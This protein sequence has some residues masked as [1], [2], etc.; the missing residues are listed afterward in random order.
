MLDRAASILTENLRSSTLYHGP[1]EFEQGSLDMLKV[2]ASQCGVTVAPSFHPHAF[3]DI[4]VNGFGVE[5]KYTKNDTWLAVA[6]SIFEGMRDPSVRCVYVILGKTGG[7]AEVRWRRYEECITHV[8]VSNAP[9]FVVEMDG[10]RTPLFELLSVGYDEFSTF[11]AEEK[12]RHVRDYSRGRL[13]KGERLWWLEPS[14]SL[15]IEVRSYMSLSQEEKRM[16]R[17]EAALLCPQV[18]AGSRVR[19]KYTDAALYLLMHHGVF[20]PQARDLFS[21]GSVAL[22]ADE[23]R[24]G[25]YILRALHDIQDLMRDAARRLDD[26]LFMEYWGEGCPPESRVERWLEKADALAKDWCPSEH[27]FFSAN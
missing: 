24:G 20:C 4:T 15:P 18:C 14:H 17:S 7:E 2:A 12:M 22:R 6:N 16:L 9:R 3:P 13:R 25:N 23:T 26:E 1:S 11:T 19:N 21:A 10:D 27:L 8:R 5:V